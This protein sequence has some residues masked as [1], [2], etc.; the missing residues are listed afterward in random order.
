MT[1][2]AKERSM[3]HEEFLAACEDDE[4]P[5][6]MKITPFAGGEIWTR[7][8]R[9]IQRRVDLDILKQ[10]NAHLDSISKQHPVDLWAPIRVAVRAERIVGIYVSQGF[11]E[12]TL[13]RE[14][15]RRPLN[16]RWRMRRRKIFAAAFKC[17][18]DEYPR[19]Q[20]IMRQPWFGA[21]PYGRPTD[22]KEDLEAAERH[23]ARRTYL[24]SGLRQQA[25]ARKVQAIAAWRKAQK[26]TGELVAANAEAATAE[27]LSPDNGRVRHD[28]VITHGARGPPIKTKRLKGVVG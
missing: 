12:L 4:F 10:L 22:T 28:C 21:N 18:A 24:H 3:T 6:E 7:P 2:D 19:W 14:E 16:V 17:P 11:D 13:L 9:F 23:V 8:P 27:A 15:I 26:L 1:A 25:L 20:R 5:F